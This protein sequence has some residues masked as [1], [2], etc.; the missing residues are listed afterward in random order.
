MREKRRRG[1]PI[2]AQCKTVSA[3]VSYE[4]RMVGFDDLFATDCS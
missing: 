3:A 4:W 1:K 2:G